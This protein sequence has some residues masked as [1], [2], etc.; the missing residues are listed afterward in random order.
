MTDITADAPLEQ[1]TITL[2]KPVTL[3]TVSYTTLHLREPTAAEWEQ[4]DKLSGVAADT[5]AVA[6]VSGV[7]LPAVRM[8]GTRDLI[9]ASRF[10]A[11]FLE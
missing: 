2:R 7:P 8:I 5:V 3:G 1:L 11:G 10:L 6:T 4:W 9:R